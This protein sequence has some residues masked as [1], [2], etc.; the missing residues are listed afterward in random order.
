MTEFKRSNIIMFFIGL[1]AATKVY[2]GGIIALS[3]LAV[4]VAAPILLFSN[5]QEYK[6]SE[7][8]IVLWLSLVMILGCFIA[9]LVNGVHW[10]FF[11]TSGMTF[12]SIFAMVTVFYFV[13]RKS[14]SGIGWFFTGLLISTVISIFVLNP[15][16][17]M[18]ER[19]VE[20]IGQADVTEQMEGVLFWY[21]KIGQLLRL[22]TSGWY[23]KVPM[24]YSAIAPIIAAATAIFV[25]VSGR[26]FAAMGVLSFALIVYCRKS[27]RRMG[28]LGR[29]FVIFVIMGLCVAVGIKNLYSYTASTGLL[30]EEARNKYFAQ[31]HGD[32]SFLRILIGG[33]TEFFIAIRAMIDNPIVG[34]GPAAE[35]KKG[36]VKEFLRKYGDQEDYDSYIR[37]RMAFPDKVEMIP[38]H[39]IFT[40]FWGN[41]GI[42]GLVFC[43]YYLYLLYIYFRRYA[44]SIPQL[45]GYFSLAIPPSIF[46]LF[47]N[48]Y[49]ERVTWPLL[50]TCLLL[51]RAVGKGKLQLP[52]EME[53]EARKYE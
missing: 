35:D 29:H 46:S 1:G 12:Y 26:G 20:L 48:P 16:I 49:S 32:S 21:P 8:T 13:L 38:Q 36:Y 2:L 31:T 33:R 47:F 5:Y 45:F 41:S 34:I 17:L 30:G 28:S 18:D 10:I 27:R 14:F 53:M 50:I 9:C 25:S 6:R 43:I 3:E 19:S 39:S 42:S 24:I 15:Q 37:Y 11:I 51:A 23:F 4:F 22:P 7:I 40:Q 44:A 52:Y